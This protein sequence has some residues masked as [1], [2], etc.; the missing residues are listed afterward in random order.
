MDDPMLKS[1]QEA[2]LKKTSISKKLQIE[3]PNITDDSGGNILLQQKVGGYDF[4][5]GIN[6]SALLQ[7]YLTT[8]FQATNFALA[9]KQIEA[10][11]NARQ[12][13]F[14]SDEYEDD[15][16]I[17]RQTG[18]TIFLGYTSNIISSGI[19]ETIRFLVQHRMV[20]C[21]VTTAGGIEEDIIKC[22][23][24][25]YVGDF[26]LSGRQLRQNGINRIGNLLVPNDNYCLFEDWIIPILDEM[27]RE[28]QTQ[29]MIWTPSKMAT[30]LGKEINNE[31]SVLYWAYVNR[32]PIFCPA[33]TDGSLGDMIYM[34]SFRNPGLIL[35]IVGDIRRLN[36]ISMKARQTGMIIL[37]GG[38][39][40]HHI[41]NANLMRNGADYAVF[42]NTG[43]EFDG[44]DS[45]ARPDEAISWGK[46]KMTANPIK[47]YCDV[48][49]IF[50]LIVAETF[51][52]YHHYSLSK[53][54]L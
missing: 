37:G 18:C 14:E 33:L 43:Q 11:L 29:K 21:I 49:L 40:K 47:L 44:S 52:K 54:L 42:I 9:I 1:I 12:E 16:F 24:P 36:T 53:K 28:Q 45:G 2:V 30:R 20:D 5:K 38:V 31:E 35:D 10:M 17:R 50:P 7:T 8:G 6:H 41:C 19:R 15:P 48:S 3:S 26:H 46:I 4:N 25:T 39:I 51:A 22:L 34:H 23:A 13:P 27:L 32:I